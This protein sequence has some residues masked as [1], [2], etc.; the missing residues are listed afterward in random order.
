MIFFK[1]ILSIVMV[2]YLS[3]LVYND[4]KDMNS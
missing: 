4:Y 1:I 2:F 3:K